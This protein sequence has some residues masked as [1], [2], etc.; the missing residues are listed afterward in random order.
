MD[1]HSDRKKSSKI[2]MPT[3]NLSDASGFTYVTRSNECQL[4]RVLEK[5][6]KHNGEFTEGKKEKKNLNPD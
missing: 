2:I 4:D 6:G 3:R 1:I 5:R